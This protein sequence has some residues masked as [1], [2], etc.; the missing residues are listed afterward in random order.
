MK[1]FKKVISM[2]VAL[3]MICSLAVCASAAG[4][5]TFAAS[6]AEGKAGDT[7]EVVISMANNPGIVSMAMTIDFDGDALELTA[8]AFFSYR[9]NLFCFIHRI[10]SLFF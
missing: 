5:A 4:E 10:S 2:V 9:T 6:S 3:A 8:T 7:V 1:L